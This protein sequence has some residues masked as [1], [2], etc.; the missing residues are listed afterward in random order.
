MRGPRPGETASEQPMLPR[1]AILTAAMVVL[2]G[3]CASRL[4]ERL[5]LPERFTIARPQLMVHSD[6]PLPEH[7]RLLE[8]LGAQRADLA[9]RL[10]L[11]AGDE[12]IHV[13]LFETPQRFEDFMRLHH[14]EF[15]RRRAFFV[16]T[17]TRLTVYAQW[18]D[19]VGEDLRHEATHGYLHSVVRNLPLWL[20]EGLAEYY[21][22]PPTRRGANRQHIDR[23]GEL[24]RRDA[25]Q[26]DLR[27]LER[28][29]PP[30]DM[31]QDEYAESWAWVHFL[32]ESRPEHAEVLRGYLSDLRREAAPVPL[33]VRLEHSLG[34][35]QAAAIEHVR[36]V[37][38]SYGR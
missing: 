28:I 22:A 4:G 32:L 27:Q 36:A 26:P 16:E 21:E 34:R 12:P 15:P 10:G 33:S 35:P 3:G 23:L 13:Y 25:W 5:T 17:D 37:A 2:P 38:A 29:G 7:H 19:R 30:R 31:T 24:L 9:C 20:D 8:D 18:G 14:P 6:V 11:P 1:S